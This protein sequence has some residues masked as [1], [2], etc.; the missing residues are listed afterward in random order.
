M[1]SELLVEVRKYGEGVLIA[2]QSPSQLI[3]DAIDNTTLKIVHDLQG[4]Q[5]R[6]AVGKAIKL[7][8]QDWNKLGNLMPGQGMVIARGHR[9]AQVV[10]I[11]NYKD[12]CEF[13]SYLSNNTVQKYMQR[14]YGRYP[15][16][17]LS[18]QKPIQG[19]ISSPPAQAA[20]QRVAELI[21]NRD[22]QYEA[23]IWQ[24]LKTEQWTELID[25]ISKMLRHTC[26]PSETHF[27]VAW[28]M[29]QVHQASS[30]PDELGWTLE[31]LA[32]FATAYQLSWAEIPAL[33][34][35]EDFQL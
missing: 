29:Y 25:L 4:A 23:S 30:A 10:Q 16:E 14:F 9:Q 34:L 24:A 19:K 32:A 33:E 27:C 17:R 15:V 3:R 35:W 8:E 13:D 31:N 2:E 12:D 22:R 18:R 6:E 1:F 26:S 28:M 11:P 21:Q 5:E 20:R 7:S